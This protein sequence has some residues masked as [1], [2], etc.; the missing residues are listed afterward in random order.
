VYT[1]QAVAIIDRQILTADAM[2]VTEIENARKEMQNISDM[3]TMNKFGLK[4]EEEEPVNQQQLRKGYLGGMGKATQH[5]GIAKESAK[6]CTFSGSTAAVM[7]VIR[8]S[9]TADSSDSH[10]RQC[11]SARSELST[12]TP[13][14]PSAPS[15]PLL[16]ERGALMSSPLIPIADRSPLGTAPAPGGKVPK[17]ELASFCQPELQKSSSFNSVDT[18]KGSKFSAST[19]YPTTSAGVRVVIG[20]V[21]DCRAVLSESGTAVELTTDHHPCMPSEKARV[22]AAGGVIR[23]GRVNGVLAVTRSIG[24]IMYKQFDMNAPVPDKPLDESKDGGIW[25]KSQHV[26]S[27]PDVVDFLVQP[28]HEFIVLASDG[29]HI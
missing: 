5:E 9:D 27:K 17:L 15:P 2:R 19:G 3:S 23:G 24:D 6:P 18:L 25:A 21:G 13:L 26:I 12:S 10:S 29:K 8:K 14:S 7:I 28:A 20:H 4:E 1:K 11:N 16:K 22:E